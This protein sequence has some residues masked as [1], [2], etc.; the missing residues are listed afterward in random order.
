M[1]MVCEHVEGVW[2]FEMDKVFPT[3][4]LLGLVP[5][6][7]KRQTWM[8]YTCVVLDQIPSKCKGSLLSGVTNP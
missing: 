6:A 1:C 3:G 4:E 7:G 5:W 2:T 8:I